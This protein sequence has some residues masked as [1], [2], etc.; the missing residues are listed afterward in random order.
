MKR[1]IIYRDTRDKLHRVSL[2]L[3]TPEENHVDI[4]KLHAL[5]AGVVPV[6]AWLETT[7]EV[8]IWEDSTLYTTE[9]NITEVKQ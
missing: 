2:Y 4:M 3:G 7:T 1:S 8:E 6:E 5:D 9:T